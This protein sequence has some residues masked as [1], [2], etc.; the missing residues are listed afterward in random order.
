MTYKVL[1]VMMTHHDL[2]IEQMNIVIA[3]FNVVFKERNI[4]I[5]SSKNYE[6]FDYV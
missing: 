2:K 6:D 1:F 3:F 4:F 5:E